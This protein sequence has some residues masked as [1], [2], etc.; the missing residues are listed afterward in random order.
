[1]AWQC[2]TDELGRSHWCTGPY[3][4]T[5][6]GLFG[7]PP[8]VAQPNCHRSSSH[9]SPAVT[10]DASQPDH[11]GLQRCRIP[12]G[13]LGEG[14]ESAARRLGIMLADANAGKAIPNL[15]GAF[16]S[17]LLFHNRPVSLP[18]Y[19]WRNNYMVEQSKQDV[20]GQLSRVA[21]AFGTN[22]VEALRDA[23][24]E[25]IAGPAASQMAAH[26]RRDFAEELFYMGTSALTPSS[27]RR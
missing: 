12:T 10:G 4:R 2:L 20:Y 27:E 22:G 11:F 9:E 16:R 25:I 17:I 14:I 5:G 19:D 3:Q 21:R 24:G 15:R 18:T 7:T 1:M 23:I 26:H 13:P 8:K 6:R